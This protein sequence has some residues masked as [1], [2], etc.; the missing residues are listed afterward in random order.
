MCGITG[1]LDNKH[2]SQEEL[3]A[4]VRRMAAT[5][6]H[7]GPDD[8]GVWA[9]A[10]SGI[11]LG[12][13]R[14]KVLD[15]SEHAQQPMLSACGQLCLV[16]NGEIYNHVALRRELEQL[17][18]RFR[19]HGD[20][21]VLLAALSQWGVQETL[22]RLVGMFAFAVWDRKNRVL[23]L[24]RDRVG[25]K[26]LYYG[27]QE[28][29]LL[30]GSELRS[31]RAHPRFRGE[32]EHRAVGLF[33]R[34]NYIPS[35]WSIYRGIYKLPPGTMLRVAPG[36]GLSEA[37]P[38]SW[39]NLRDVIEHGS[40]RPFH[41]TPEEA[42]DELDRL[43]REA[44]ASEMEADVP[45]GSFLSGGIDSSTVVAMMQSQS[46]RPVKTF[47]VAFEESDYN[48]AGWAKQVANHL[49][50]QH[51]ELR[52]TARET[53]EQIPSLCT[54]YDEPFADSSQIPTLSLAKLTRQHVTVSLSGDG[55][56][57]L[58]CGYDRYFYLRK[59]WRRVAWCPAGL[60]R[61][62]ARFVRHLAAMKP[63][64]TTARR[65]RTLAAFLSP[66]T[67]GAFYVHFNTHWREPAEILLHTE[68]VETPAADLLTELDCRDALETM[69]G[70]D[71]QVYLA[72]DLL[73]KLDRASMAVGL[74]A[75][76][77]L[78]DH[79]I[80]EFAWRLP[81]SL[82]V[83]KGQTKWILRRVLERYIPRQWIERPK[84]G[85]A[86]P[87]GAWLRGPLRDWAEDLLDERRLR[88]EAIFR[89]EP[90]RQKWRE[91]LSGRINW[92]Y[93]LWDVLVL[94]SWLAAQRG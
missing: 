87:L 26:P 32:I 44:V 15:L 93:L 67:A 79:R 22:P 38:Q 88:R 19:G 72:D 5:L 9:D 4:I 8:E 1:F 65:L 63:S 73:V 57:E 78:L 35:P 13:R 2:V 68:P 94:Q 92:Q 24:A 69:M 54:I 10:S 45:L 46:S 36:S 11:A 80:V 21:E 48:E 85:F 43:L 39:W 86:I 64:C 70:W 50:T 31:L 3:R 33:L 51:T 17:G 30:F 83:R 14:L 62:A 28:G 81:L 40:Q 76:V 53:L 47:T 77:P 18:H 66:G 37:K 49:G 91:H 6:V 74:E 27:W 61:T 59:L 25:I 89:P 16:Y 29:C 90:V 34:H 71:T 58:F 23:T 75:R 52:V 20:T 42:M 41:G 82:K 12:H 84:M 56:D 55:G 7:R 60:R